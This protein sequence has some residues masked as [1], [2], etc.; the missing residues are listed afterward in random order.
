MR[1]LYFDGRLSFRDD[2]PVPEPSPDEALVRVLAA[3]ICSTDLEIAKGYMGF[4][5]VPGHEF[6]GLVQRCAVDEGLEGKRVVGEINAGCGRCTFCRSGLKNHC[7]DRTVLGILNRDGAFSDYLTL[8]AEN[9][10]MVPDAVTDEEAVFTEP[11]ASAFEILEEVPIHS[12]HRVCVLGDGRLGLLVAQVLGLTGCSLTVAGRHRERFSMMEGLSLR[13]ALI[14]DVPE[15]SFDFVVD[16]TGSP[17]GL[18]LALGLVVPRGT[19]VLKTTLAEKRAVDL[20]R[21]VIDEVTLVGSRCGPFAP[22]IEALERGDVKVRPLV[23]EIMPV[24]AG[25]EAFELAARRGALKVILKM[26][27]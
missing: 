14:D 16:C 8:P 27:L 9:L 12:D 21:V 23:Q 5:G 22:A 7:P 13:P 3:G 11:L 20:N 25:Q 19:V 2:Y 1:A 24:E 10:H 17:K 15:R 26:E 4:R 6:V 18:D